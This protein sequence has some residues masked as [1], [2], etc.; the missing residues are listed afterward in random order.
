M[1]G[2]IPKKPQHCAKN[3]SKLRKARSKRVVPPKE[4]YNQLIAQFQKV[5]P[6]NIHMTNII[7][8]Q[9]T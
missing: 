4:E 1:D 7:C 3:Y 9:H 8:S 2:E 5:S 6:E